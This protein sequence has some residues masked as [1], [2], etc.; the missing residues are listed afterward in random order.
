MPRRKTNKEDRPARLSRFGVIA[1]KEQ[2]VGV[3]SL[4]ALAWIGVTDCIV[5]GRLSREL[6]V[7]VCGEVE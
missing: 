6:V 2:G 4:V 1:E 3:R 5:V 7:S